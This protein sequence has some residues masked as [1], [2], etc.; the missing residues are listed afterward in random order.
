MP[1]DLQ[2]LKCFKNGEQYKKSMR[3]ND[4]DGKECTIPKEEQQGRKKPLRDQG[5]Q[6]QMHSHHPGSVIGH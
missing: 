4:N 3:Q 5:A 6:G 1:P 2:V